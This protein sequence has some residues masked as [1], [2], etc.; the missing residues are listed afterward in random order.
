M[1]KQC[2]QELVKG[3]LNTR[4]VSCHNVASV[5][6]GSLGWNPDSAEA[7]NET[8]VNFRIRLLSPPLALIRVGCNQIVLC[9]HH[10]A[11]EVGVLVSFC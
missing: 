2:L 5:H 6:L 7:D 3:G 4:C 10:H 11:C 1:H 9:N 8:A